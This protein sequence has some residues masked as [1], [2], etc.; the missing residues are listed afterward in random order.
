M[1]GDAWN[2]PIVD[3]I[4]ETTGVMRDRGSEGRKQ[5]V[6][7]SKPGKQIQCGR[8]GDRETWGIL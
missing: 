1:L 6:R 2:V 3:M 7:V 4:E 8:E 5:R